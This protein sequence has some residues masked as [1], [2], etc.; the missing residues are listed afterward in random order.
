[1]PWPP[2][3]QPPVPAAGE[4]RRLHGHGRGAGQLQGGHRSDP[5][6]GRPVAGSGLGISARG[7]TMSTVGLVPG[8]DRLTGG[9]PGH[10]RPV[11]ART[12]RRAAR[13][14]VPINTRWKVDE[15]L[16]A[17]R[18]YH[19]ATGRRVSIEY[20]LIRDINDQAWR[21]DL[22]GQKLRQRGRGWVHVNPIPL[23]PTPGSKWTAS[24][25]A[26]SSSS[27]SGCGRTASRRPF[28]TR[29]GPTST[30][31]AVSWLPRPREPPKAA[32]R[33]RARF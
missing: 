25:E 13:Q 16:D 14:L 5:A 27:S 18:R 26:S 19:E 2:M 28:V 11:P 6:P 31:P 4:Q 15:A 3:P 1:M 21:A 33:R 30:A 8:I 32:E 23:N 17:A 20:A 9:H 12:R 24:P 29:A 10:A 22:L 7:L